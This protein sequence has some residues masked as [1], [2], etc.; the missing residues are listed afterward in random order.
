M[1]DGEYK[2]VFADI[3]VPRWNYGKLAVEFWNHRQGQLTTIPETDFRESARA[4][5]F[6]WAENRKPELSYF[7]RRAQQHFREAH[8]DTSDSGTFVAH[9]FSEPVER[10]YWAIL[11]AMGAR[12]ANRGEPHEM[13]GPAEVVAAIRWFEQ[14]AEAAGELTQGFRGMVDRL[15]AKW[16]PRLED[17]M[18]DTVP[19][20]VGMRP[21]PEAGDMPF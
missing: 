19:E 11:K 4:I 14:K 2:A 9:R 20:P 17:A 1:T 6:D 13:H 7:L 3:I 15:L 8:A 12:P 10:A 18:P 16:E 5:V 21:E